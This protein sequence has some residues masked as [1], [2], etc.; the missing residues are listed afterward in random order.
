MK[1][2]ENNE[3]KEAHPTKLCGIASNILIRRSL[4]YTHVKKCFTVTSQQLAHVFFV[5]WRL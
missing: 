4:I 5:S 3:M 1:K 2:E